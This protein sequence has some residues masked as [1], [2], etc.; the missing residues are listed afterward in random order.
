MAHETVVSFGGKAK[1]VH[2][3][4][5]ALRQML[6]RA[7]SRVDFAVVAARAT[8]L[9]AETT[10]TVSR[11]A[12]RAIKRI[13]AED[14]ITELMSAD[15][16]AIGNVRIDATD[17]GKIKGAF[18][19]MLERSWVTGLQQ[20]MD[21]TTKV[22]KKLYTSEARKIKFASLRD[23]SAAFFEANSF[24]MAGNLTDSMRAV[25]QRELLQAMKQG[26]RPEVVAADIY[27]SLIRKGM[28]TLEATLSEEE[29]PHVRDLT[30]ELLLDALP[31]ANV[32]AYLNT[33]ARTNTF[34]AL[35]E[36]RYA[37]FTDPA[38]SDF[39]LALMYSAILDDRTT[40]ICETLDGSIY[41]PDNPVWEM[42][43]PPNHYNCRSLLV[44]V[45]A[46]DA[47]DGMESD[48]PTV[49]PQEGFK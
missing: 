39:V 29:R 43:R 42:Y 5:A 24:R 40:V 47:W 49:E 17:T 4:R 11:F 30:E 26:K 31:T 36:A 48:Q 27:D 2:F 1:P 6:S 38:V 23:R 16:D 32:P 33:L 20:A 14:R 35:N 7:E 8:S 25:I 3:S 45:T 28:T 34:E 15:A 44:A 12:A 37:E 22:S 9:E 19:E 18:R 13:V 10:R 46:L 21:E 41:T